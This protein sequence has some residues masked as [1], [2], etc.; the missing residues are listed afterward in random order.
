MPRFRYQRQVPYAAGRVFDLVADVERYPQFL[1]GW[2]QARIVA[3]QGDVLTVEQSLGGWG[4]SWRFRTRATFERPT[5]I[6]IETREH[7]FEHLLQVWRFEPAG[8]DSTL[9][10][11]EADYELR[12]LPLRSVLAVVFDQGFR[13]TLDAFEARAHELLD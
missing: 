11:L 8:E 4:F 3:R 12:D 1:P 5:R 6:R 7:P 13:Q 10:T 2:Q 9:V